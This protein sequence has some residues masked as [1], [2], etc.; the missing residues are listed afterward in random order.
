VVE[1][2]GEQHGA[3]AAQAYDARP[4]TDGLDQ[5]WVAD[6]T[7]VP[8]GE[9]LVYLAVVLDAFSRKVIGWA[10]DDHLEARLAM[11]ALDMALAARNPPAESLIHHSDRGV[12]YACGEYSQRLQ[13][14]GVALSMSRVGN[15]YDN[16][17]PRAS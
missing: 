6:T 5:I 1:V 11:A 8:L 7:Y 3:D 9:A 16:A 2:D 17:R 10:L 12:Q 15:P 4:Q 13:A 14:R